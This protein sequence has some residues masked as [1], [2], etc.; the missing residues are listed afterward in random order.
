MKKLRK[1]ISLIFW[2]ALPVILMISASGYHTMITDA[3]QREEARHYVRIHAL[4]NEN[5]IK[6]ALDSPD[7]YAQKI[8]KSS[9]IIHLSE[10]HKT[11]SV[12]GMKLDMDYNVISASD[13]ELDI[14]LG[15]TDCDEC[16][17]TKIPLYSS[18]TKNLLG[19]AT[20]WF[21][22]EFYQPPENSALKKLA[23]AVL[24]YLITG[25]CVLTLNMW[26]I[27]KKNKHTQEQLAQLTA[28]KEEAA[29]IKKELA[30]QKEQ[31]KEES[32][33]ACAEL[34]NLTLHYWENV[35]QESPVDL[36]E[37]CVSAGK[38]IWN[39]YNNTGTI[40]PKKLLEYCDINKM[41]KSRPRF[42]KVLSTAY[43][44]LRYK[45]VKPDNEMKNKLKQKIEEFEM[46]LYTQK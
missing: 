23:G 14:V 46:L 21:D 44:V 13:G 41:P 27:K 5:R 34:A 17:V 19:T 37:K 28:S 42:K 2:I 20:F 36:A 6:N 10:E 22:G 25:W 4:S 35:V 29:A 39:L 45:P 7:R 8:I 33:V 38:T 32:R 43:F 30:A 12:V 40:K 31:R 24:A 1:I 18:K 16:F 9:G 11:P 3:Q 26:N 15:K